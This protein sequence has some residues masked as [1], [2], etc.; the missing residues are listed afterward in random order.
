[1]ASL[2]QVWRSWWRSG[3]L[4]DIWWIFHGYLVKSSGYQMGCQLLPKKSW[5][6]RSQVSRYPPSIQSPGTTLV[7]PRKCPESVIH[8]VNESFPKQK[9][10]SLKFPKCFTAQSSMK[11]FLVK[12][13][14]IRKPWFFSHQISLGF[15]RRFSS[16]GIS[17]SNIP[18]SLWQS[19]HGH[20]KSTI[21][22]GAP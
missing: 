5:A 18:R 7:S 16:A 11:C 14:H 20:G 6:E 15:K 21:Q 2:Q 22:D 4:S 12:K 10:A 17:W 19:K 9:T 13:H 8:W 3:C 1:M